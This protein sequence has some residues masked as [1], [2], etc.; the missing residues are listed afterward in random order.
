MSSPPRKPH[1]IHS[2]ANLVPNK[3]Y[4]VF[5]LEVINTHKTKQHQL[6]NNRV[7]VQG[8]KKNVCNFIGY[9]QNQLQPPECPN[10]CGTAKL[11]Y[12]L[13]ERVFKHTDKA[14]INTVEFRLN[15]WIADSQES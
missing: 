2:Q 4:S 11:L 13:L 10:S 12:F 15:L 1:P 9:K 6:G 5:Q 14:N 7:T 3:Q 8:S